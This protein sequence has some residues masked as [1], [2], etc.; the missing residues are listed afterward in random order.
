[1]IWIVLLIVAAVMG[2]VIYFSLKSQ[3]QLLADGKIICRRIDFMESAE[4]F[5]LSA[6]DPAQVTEAVKAIDYAE[7]RTKMQ[8]SNEQ[9]LFKFTGSTWSAQLHKLRDNG[10]QVVYRFEFTSWKTRNGMPCDALSMNKLTTAVEKIFLSL[11]P[12]TQ[13]RTVPLEFKTKHSIL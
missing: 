9:Q 12:N 1:M 11:D 6:V 4:E 7:M 2:I 8:G 13:V 10:T 3:K 5:T